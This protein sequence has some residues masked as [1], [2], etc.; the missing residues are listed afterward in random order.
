MI[1]LKFVIITLFF[2]S[3]FSTLI[4]T[5]LYIRKA[6]ARGLVVKDMYKPGETMVPHMGG[7]VI[8]TGIVIGLIMSQFS[9]VNM[10]PLLL[11][12]FVVILYAIYGLVDDLLAFK[13]KITKLWVLF[14]FAV[15]ISILTVDTNLNLLFFN[16]ELGWFYAFIF[17]PFYIM[18]VAHLINFHEGFNGLATG[19]T[20]I[21]LIFAAIK[22]YMLNGW[23]YSILLVP[24][25]AATLA[26]MYFH[27]Y[28]AKVLCGNVG[29]Y[30]VGSALGAFLVLAN[31]EFF[32]VIILMPHIINFILWPIWC[33]KM[34]KYPYQ[35]FG[36]L[37]S[38]GTVETPNYFTLK[39]A[40][41][42][43][44]KVTEWQA[45]LICYGLTLFFCIIGLI[46]F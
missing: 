15:P 37:R 28:P 13:N 45:T 16:L 19:S 40:V 2:V 31:I 18:V 3:F 21:M 32:G 5:K 4:L 41:C 10:I 42:R 33:L 25:I 46:F 11:F 34:K 20:L 38:D 35:K 44:F 36:K 43:M 39:Y 12:Y 27:F 24:L 30:L 29:T 23:S 17:A 9:R 22:S 1:P 8:L 14:F 7:I 6:I 26:F